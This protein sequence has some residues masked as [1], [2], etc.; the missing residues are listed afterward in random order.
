MLE[1]G[2]NVRHRTDPVQAVMQDWYPYNKED[3]MSIKN[4][5]AAGCKEVA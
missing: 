1:P 3:V 2:K 4:I 5:A